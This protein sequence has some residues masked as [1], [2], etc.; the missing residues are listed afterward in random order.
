MPLLLVKDLVPPPHSCVHPYDE[1]AKDIHPTMGNA[2][3]HSHTI[4]DKQ[5]PEIKNI[6]ADH[7]DRWHLPR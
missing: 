4:P 7:I 1:K 6:M 2:F 3:V 5:S